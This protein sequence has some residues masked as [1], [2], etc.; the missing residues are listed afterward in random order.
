MAK[1]KKKPTTNKKPAAQTS[2]L[3]NQPTWFTSKPLH[4]AF[5]FLFCF[6]IY[7][8]TIQHDYTQ[9]DAIV[10]YDNEYT[11]QGIAGIP[12]ILKYDTFRGFFKVEGKDKLV[13]GG[14]YRPLTLVM[15][16]IGVELFGENPTIGHVMNIFWYGL[17]CVLLY[18][19]LLRMLGKRKTNYAYFVAFLTAL[20]F[21]AHPLHTEAV[22]NIKGRDE[23]IA[24]LG[25]LAAA[26]FCLRSY[27][28]KKP[29]LNILAAVIFFITLFSKE[30]AITFLGV[31]PLIFF[32][33]TKA[34]IKEIVIQIAPLLVGAIAFIAIRYSIIGG[35]IGDP[36]IEL[37]NNPFV[38]IEG[39]QY[40]HFS[41][42]E[43]L[44]T[45]FY[46]LFKYIQLLIFPHPLTHDYYPRHIGI[47]NMTS[48][49]ALG[50]LFLHLGLLVYA[51]I[52]FFKKDIISFGILFY[53]GTLLIAVSYTHLT[54]PTIC[55][56]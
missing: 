14:R 25:A 49:A 23:I 27:Q 56:V 35:G 42:S 24:L 18:L 55:S 6:V 50:S 9:D 43:R 37:M 16:A 32:F 34:S 31:I 13:S 52:R 33:F 40:V 4:A 28:E 47:L 26:Y 3:A 38:K 46:T 36:P 45:I 1:K 17:T 2:V 5:L 7:G 44:G 10:I 22:A 11:T 41:A 29:A 8:N 15:F 48:P 19:L 21:A 20:L 51:G 53:L 12:G 30:N 39:S 54:L